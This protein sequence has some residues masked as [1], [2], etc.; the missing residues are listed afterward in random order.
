ML[1]TA[2]PSVNVPFEFAL[3][4]NLLR[5]GTFPES[6]AIFEQ[7]FISS[8]NFASLNENTKNMFQ[9]RILG[10]TSYY[11]GATPDKFAQK[12][13]H[14]LNITMG[15]YH[16]EIYNYYEEIE[17]Q[18]EKQ[19]MKMSRGKV[20]DTMSTYSSYTRQSCNF[21]FPNISELI[22]GEKR[23]RPGM[24]RIKES[25]AVVIDEGRDIEKKKELIKSQAEVLQYIEA[26]QSFVNALV[27]YF[28]D[29]HR[30][31]EKNKHTIEDDVKTCFDKS[32][33]KIKKVDLKL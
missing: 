29:A 32:L 12:T 8:S 31:D 13:I 22:N 21:V 1:L 26:I 11:I 16:T 9:R 14:Y 6:E 23:P 10:L 2:T 4:Y 17:K 3:I 7:I 27:N 19:M 30:E 28:K 5:P 20:G 33:L 25:D 24:F 18:K 15:K